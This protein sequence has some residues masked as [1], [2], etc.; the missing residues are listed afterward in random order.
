M[1]KE[2]WGDCIGDCTDDSGSLATPSE[3]AE[4]ACMGPNKA[5]WVEEAFK[6]SKDGCDADE[7]ECILKQFS[8]ALKI[9]NFSNLV[10][11]LFSKEFTTWKGTDTF[12]DL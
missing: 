7:Y 5:E 10:E 6:D 12:S 1:Q 11:D 2:A 8:E 4:T 9:D 3:S